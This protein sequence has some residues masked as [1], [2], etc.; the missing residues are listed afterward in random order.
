MAYSADVEHRNAAGA[1]IGE[2]AGVSGGHGFEDGLL[3]IDPRLLH[4]AQQRLVLLGAGSD[5]QGVGFKAEALDVDR[6]QR[7]WLAVDSEV[8]RQD[9]EQS[10]VVLTRRKRGEFDGIGEILSPDSARVAKVVDASALLST[11]RRPA[12]AN[13]SRPDLVTRRLPRRLNRITDRI[14]DGRLVGDLAAMPALGLRYAVAGITHDA[15]FHRENEDARPGAAHVEADGDLVLLSHFASPSSTFGG[16][17]MDLRITRWSIER[18]ST[19]RSRRTWRM[20]SALRL[21]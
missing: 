17:G 18:S 16:S 9:L 5:Q 14:G 10:P 2:Y 8:L 11:D 21:K 20:E 7:R 4:G 3:D 13:H 19:A 6:M 15:A 12:N 1:L